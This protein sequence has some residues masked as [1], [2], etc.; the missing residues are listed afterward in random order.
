MVGDLGTRPPDCRSWSAGQPWPSPAIRTW[1]EGARPWWGFLSPGSEREAYG[2]AVPP[3][4]RWQP[5]E[6]QHGRSGLAPPRWS[7][8]GAPRADGRPRTG[9]GRM[10]WRGHRCRA[11]GHREDPPGHGADHEGVRRCRGGALGTVLAG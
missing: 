3:Y 1:V 8:A 9:Q 7:G 2:W 4:G 6:G 11:P 10:G 5:L